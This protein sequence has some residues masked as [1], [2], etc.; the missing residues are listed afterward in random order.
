MS[1]RNRSMVLRVIAVVGAGIV[2]LTAALT[3]L[4]VVERDRARV[5]EAETNEAELTSA[6]LSLLQSDLSGLSMAMETLLRDEEAIRMFTEGQR[7]ELTERLLPYFEDITE[8]YGVAQFQFHLPPA[9]SFLRLH[10]PDRFGD[11]LSEF[12]RTVVETNSSQSPVRGL[13]VGRGGPGTRVVYPVFSDGEH[14]GSVEFGGSIFSIL[15]ILEETFDVRYA[16][17]IQQD[18]F[19]AA[20]R[21]EAGEDDVQID[22]TIFFRYSSDLVRGALASTGQAGT[23]SDPSGVEALDRL[24]VEDA[25][26]AVY[27]IPLTDYSGASIGT[28]LALRDIDQ[29]L[30]AFR[31]AV[32]RDLGIALAIAAVVLLIVTVVVRASLRPLHTVVNV[33][34]TLAAGDFSVELTEERH[35]EVGQVLDAMRDMITRLRET[36][37]AVKTISSEVSMGSD[38]LSSTSMTVSDGASH[39]ASNLEEISSSLE[40]MESTLQHS[41]EMASETDRISSEMAGKA[42]EGGEAVDKTLQSM[43]AINER[44]AEIQDFARNT[45]LLA[46]N[47]AIEAA[48]AGESGKGFAVVAGEV[49]KLAERSASSASEISELSTESLVVAQKARDLIAA[50]VPHM[51]RMSEVMRDLSAA[52]AEQRSGAAQV[53]KA[54]LELDQLTQGN[55]S[56]AEQLAS[57]A[58]ELSGQAQQLANTCAFFSIECDPADGDQPGTETGPVR[59]LSGPV[60]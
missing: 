49:R 14:I 6:F 25:V 11:D 41:A 3:A 50:V 12:R 31:R 40:Q 55:A 36:I 42:I 56:A 1:K 59:R 29:E 54:T 5:L 30:V 23:A 37:A 28:V 60:V 13:E 2:L 53:S 8:T 35:D 33:S 51:Q 45:N 34:Q 26:H 17:G 18:V 16:I 20:G 46:L 24:T 21:F 22:D 38:Q 58:E 52:T 32:A 39:Q 47:A 19:E 48:R 15:A 27:Q 43:Q 4:Q 57:M 44:I 9:T 7:D 10:R